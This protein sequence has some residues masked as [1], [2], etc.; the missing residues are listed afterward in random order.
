MDSGIDITTFVNISGALISD[1][2]FTL[3]AIGTMNGVPGKIGIEITETSV[4]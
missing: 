3:E 1:S 2:D 4:I